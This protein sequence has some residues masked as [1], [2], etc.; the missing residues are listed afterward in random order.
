MTHGVSSA[1][2]G[3]RPAD[4]VYRNQE[5]WLVDSRPYTRRDGSPTTLA[6][7]KSYCPACGEPFEFTLPGEAK[8]F[9]PIRR[10][11]EHKRPGRTTYLRK[12]K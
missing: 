6:L 3:M 12:K 11:T 9:I 8:K 5:Y 7:W 1:R 2:Q 4:R 10:C